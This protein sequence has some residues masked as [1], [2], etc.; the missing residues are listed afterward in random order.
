MKKFNLFKVLGITLLI[1]T[2]ISWV[3]PAGFYLNGTFESIETTIPIGI[4]DLF[5]LPLITIV[6][7]IDYGLL[8]LAIGGFYGVLNKTGVYSKL[9]NGIV[10]K[11]SKKKMSFLITTIILFVLLTSI[12]GSVNLIFALVP[13]FVAVL[14]KLGYSKI[15]S[16]ASTIGSILV[17]QIATTFGTN[18]WGQLKVEFELKMTDLILVRSILLIIVLALF[19]ILIRKT[20]KTETKK[21]KSLEKTEVPLYS[22]GKSKKST[23]PLIM[24]SIITFVV[25]IVGVY[26]WFDAFGIEIFTKFYNTI[27]TFKIGKY[28]IISNILG[29]VSEIGFFNNYDIMIVLLVTSFIIGFTYKL[30][31]NDIME[32]LTDG[33]KQMLKP[34]IYATL[35]SIVFIAFKMYGV[36][37]ITTIINKFISGSEEFNLFGTIGSGLVAGFAYND[38][39]EMLKVIADVFSLYDLK[40]IPVIAFIFQTMYSIVMV[41]AP[42]SV[43]LLAG[44]SYLDISYKEWV[45]YIWKFLLII[46]AIVVAISFILATL[47]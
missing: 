1:V 23:L 17:G 14:L 43:F 7:F 11:K 28:P 15:T 10:E 40:L 32:G 38:F 20:A 5:R 31:F 27:L 39:S 22:E 2:L 34:A 36:D 13:F 9:V 37:F 26:N 6:N 42:T 41:I 44:L 8:F 29:G 4:I 21:T 3:I 33:A 24:F 18:I 16:F 45:K 12:V 30:K 19:I 35:A 25:L 46:F 47:I